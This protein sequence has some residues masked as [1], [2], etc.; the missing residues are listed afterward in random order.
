MIAHDLSVGSLL[1]SPLCEDLYDTAVGACGFVVLRGCALSLTS[2][3][4]FQHLQ[5]I[6]E[7]LL[8]LRANNILFRDISAR[9]FMLS[10]G[11][12]RLVVIDYGF[13]LDLSGAT[14]AQTSSPPAAVSQPTPPAVA[15]HTQ[16]SLLLLK[17][18][19]TLLTGFRLT[20]SRTRFS[21]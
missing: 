16:G 14:Q 11:T 19:P 15:V 1:L 12:D 17:L 13:A 2:T 8:L 18:L 10:K 9:H 6:N 20:G 7:W 3:G 21:G 4:L 5:Q